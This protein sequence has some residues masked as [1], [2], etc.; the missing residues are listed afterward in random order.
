LARS[1]GL[2]FGW[3][4]AVGAGLL[5]LVTNG[6][7]L[8]GLS[9]FDEAIL[10]TLEEATGR[11][12]MRGDLNLRALITFWG[13]GALAPLAGAIADRIGVRPLMVVGLMLLAGGY[14]AYGSV[15]SL[16]QVYGIHVA[17]ALTLSCCG[18]VVNVM[19]VSKWFVKNR[20]LA[21]GIALAGTSLGS[22]ALAPINAWLIQQLGW[23]DAFQWTA[24]V[25]LLMIPLVLFVLRERPDDISREMPDPPAGT[26]VS[27]EPWG[28]SYGQALVTSNFWILALIAMCTFYS[29]LAMSSHVYL[30]MRDAGFQPQVA[31]FGQTVMFTTGLA[32]KVCSGMLADRFGRK[33]IFVGTLILMCGGAWAIPNAGESGIWV[34]LLFFGLGWGGLY[35]LLQLLA[36]DFFGVRHLGKILG[37]ITVLDTFGGGL[38]PFVTGVLY[39]RAGSYT[40]PFT[41]IAG[42]VTLALVLST[43]YRT[44]PVDA[45]A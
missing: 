45:R 3:V 31:A 38:G 27:G 20:G 2:Y 34:A 29:I 21:I 42:L 13:S 44:Q 10:R 26:A 1:S 23:R 25:P 22:A 37:T 16:G 18:L 8:G 24:I 14:F 32:A 17:L 36:A 5:L 4:I 41:I 40:M 39:D 6:M 30:H 19:L 33:P 7:T 15:A 9:V 35:T 11:D 28:M 12:S 43:L